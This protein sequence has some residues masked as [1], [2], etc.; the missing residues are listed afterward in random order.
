MLP[1]LSP[2][3]HGLPVCRGELRVR[4]PG[5]GPMLPAGS[6]LHL[7]GT[8]RTFAPPVT[9]SAWPRDPR[10]RGFLLVDSV[11]A[12][13]P[14]GPEAGVWLR[15]RA[16]ADAALEALFPDHLELMEA[17]VLGRREYM[18]SGTRDRF[19]RAGLSH[20]LAIS[21]MHVGLL[22]GVVLLLASALRLPRRYGLVLTL[23]IT[24][25]YLLVIGAG[26]S[27][28]RAGVMI[29]L[30]IA[31]VLIQRP[32]AAAPMV[33]AAAFAILAFRPRAILDV[34]FQLSF[35]GVLGILLLRAPLLTLTPDQLH[36]RAAFR[37]AV[38]AFV[39]GVA[40][41]LATAPVVAH[42]FGIVAPISILAGIPAVPLMSL[43]LIGALGAV[44]AAAP[45]PTVA[46]LLASGAAL[47]IDLLDVLATTAAAAPFGHG[48]VPPPPWWAWSVAAGSGAAG[49]V[50]LGTA[51]KRLRWIVA[52][53]STIA[54]LMLWPVV[55]RAGAGGMEV[56]FIDVGQGDAIAIRTPAA[57]WVLIDAGPASADFDAGERR[58]IPFLRDRGARRLEAIVLTHPDLDHIGGAPAILRQMNVRY[59]FEPG[60]AAGK[61]S[62][63]EVLGEL[64]P[65]RT[66]WRA[67]RS[68]RTLEL[69]DVRF[70]FLWPDAEMVDVSE[71]ANQISAVVRVTYGNFELLLTGDVGVEVEEVLVQRYGRTLESD[72]L[73]LGHH[74]SSTSTSDSFLEAVEPELAIVSAGRRNR[75]GHPAPAV[76]LRV[77]DRGIP[78]A[79]TDV[80]GTVSLE[81]TAGGNS[82]RRQDW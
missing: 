81:I 61:S 25:G 24:W 15:T 38:E 48:I 40:A 27:A 22:A 54:T 52:A 13:T 17:L 23:A 9:R 11:V 50:L 59:V 36:G 80:E 31:A 14:T 3:V 41:F 16:R 39:V 7:I 46:E 21:G 5:T 35:L 51:P 79:R 2:A 45:L 44:L 73:K 77:A 42:H 62:Y 12:A 70:D 19:A 71:D 76:L 69:D 1:L 4:M 26:F 29:S 65:V 58:V 18:D 63:L 60:Y 72:L 37:A 32:S 33:A 28:I 68:G 30:A 57:R 64:Q 74:G 55:V 43:A 47:S 8:W 20:L 34:G 53:G 10:F 67:V 75:Y 49:W 78:V 66:G 82:W 56:H 6:R